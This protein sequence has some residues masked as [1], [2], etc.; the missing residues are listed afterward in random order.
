[1]NKLDSSKFKSL[2]GDWFPYLE[3]LIETKE[4]YNLYQEFKQCKE[5]ITPKSSNLYKFLE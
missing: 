2:L 1:M 4:M 3:K 5:H